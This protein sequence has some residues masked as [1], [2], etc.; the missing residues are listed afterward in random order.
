MLIFKSQED[1]VYIIYS[2][3]YFPLLYLS[4]GS[5]KKGKKFVSRQQTVKIY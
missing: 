1:L 2:L 5:T 4:L 3:P